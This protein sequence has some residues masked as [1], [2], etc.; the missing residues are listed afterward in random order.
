MV[1]DAVKEATRLAGLEALRDELAFSGTELVLNGDDFTADEVRAYIAQIRKEFPLDEIETL[2]V[3]KTEG[4]NA[5]L[6]Y[7]LRPPKF[8]RIRRITGYLVGNLDRFNNAKRAEEHDRVKHDM[9]TMRTV[10]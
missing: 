7:T 5:A 10:A 9:R 1:D 3:A 4:D 8:Q 2:T 6:D